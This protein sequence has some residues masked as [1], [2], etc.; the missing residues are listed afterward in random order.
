MNHC[1]VEG[2]ERLMVF[3]DQANCFLFI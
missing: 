2:N 3:S 1:V